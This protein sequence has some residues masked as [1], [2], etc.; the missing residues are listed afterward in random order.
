MLGPSK[1]AFELARNYRKL[2]TKVDDYVEQKFDKL[3]SSEL[4]ELLELS[5]NLF[6]VAGTAALIGA[7]L[8]LAEMADAATQIK[9]A[10]ARL[11]AAIDKLDDVRKVIAA[12]TASINLAG[13]IA[14][15][16][17]DVILGA[18]KNLRGPIDAL[19]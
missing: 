1:N 12:V 15:G 7:R 17:P 18:L 11:E 10:T 16:R 5:D 19:T 4:V 3:S 13:A 2:A 14:S 8:D 9:S 6:R